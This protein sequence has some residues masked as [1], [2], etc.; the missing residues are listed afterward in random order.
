MCAA[1]PY[2]EALNFGDADGVGL[3]GDRPCAFR[4]GDGAG[5]VREDSPAAEASIAAALATLDVADSTMIT[6]TD[7]NG[8]LRAEASSK[9]GPSMRS[10]ATSSIRRPRKVPRPWPDK[11]SAAVLLGDAES[12]SAH[13]VSHGHRGAA[14]GRQQARPRRGG[15]G[16]EH[17]ARPLARWANELALVFSPA[18]ATTSVSWKQ[19]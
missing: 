3:R 1:N 12:T 9:C 16:D 19:P 8:R 10:N 15:G 17:A 7:Q 6:G 5:G 2:V 4:C 13:G 18:Q 11:I 14:L